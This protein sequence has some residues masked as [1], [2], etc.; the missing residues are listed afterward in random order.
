MYFSKL[1]ISF[2][3]IIRNQIYNILLLDEI[4]FPLSQNATICYLYKILINQNNYPV[5]CHKNNAKQGTVFYYERHS[6]IS[7]QFLFLIQTKQKA[8]DFFYLTIKENHFLYKHVL[9]FLFPIQ[10]M[11]LLF[12]FLL[13]SNAYYQFISVV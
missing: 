11:I 3:L 9:Y 7:F 2:S 4:A 5:I 12:R 6:S 1:K 8:P 13:F 10:T